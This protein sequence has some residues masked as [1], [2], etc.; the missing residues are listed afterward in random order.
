MR[1]PIAALLTVTL[2]CLASGCAKPEQKF[3]R[4]VRNMTEFAHLGEMQ[5][6]VQQA[7]LF[8]TTDYAYTTGMAKGFAKSLT[9]TVVGVYE[10]ITFPFP[11]YTPVLTNYISA[12]PVYPAGHNDGLPADPIFEPD[13][14]LGFSGGVTAPMVPGNKFMIF[15]Q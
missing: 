7:G 4:G 14:Y 13:T 1:I 8:N 3:G 2:L 6:S 12:A 11:P 5:Y 15:D 10:V 9:R